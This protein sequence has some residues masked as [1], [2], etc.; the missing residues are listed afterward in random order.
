M[1]L[2]VPGWYNLDQS[3]EVGTRRTFAFFK[4]LPEYLRELAP[5]AG[6]VFHCSTIPSGIPRRPTS[7]TRP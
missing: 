1:A 6:P 3:L 7:R 2:W 5:Y 4:E